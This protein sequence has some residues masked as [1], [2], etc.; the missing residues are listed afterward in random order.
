MLTALTRQAANGLHAHRPPPPFSQKAVAA[1]PKGRLPHSQRQPFS[2][3]KTAF[4]RPKRRPPHGILRRFGR[5][6]NAKPWLTSIYKTFHNGIFQSATKIFRADVLHKIHALTLRGA[7][8]LTNR[9]D[10]AEYFTFPLKHKIKYTYITLPYHEKYL[11]LP[12]RR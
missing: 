9:K 8:L 12:R 4:R 11:P 2:C 5:P 6:L 7:E 3:S 10:A 1:T